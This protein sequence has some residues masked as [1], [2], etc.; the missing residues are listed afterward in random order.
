MGIDLKGSL[1]QV[2]LHRYCYPDYYLIKKVIALFNFVYLEKI[3]HVFYWRFEFLHSKYL[4][5]LLIFCFWLI[6]QVHG[7]EGFLELMEENYESR[8]SCGLEI[9]I[10]NE[11]N[12]LNHCSWFLLFKVSD[13]FS[14]FSW[15]PYL[16]G[17]WYVLRD[18]PCAFS[19]RIQGKLTQIAHLLFWDCCWSS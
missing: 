15:W 1:Y 3:F 14:S 11:I 13:T 6:P 4:N 12:W 2:D 17:K 8:D 16:T 18:F 9:S 10:V 5:F 7:F 19:W